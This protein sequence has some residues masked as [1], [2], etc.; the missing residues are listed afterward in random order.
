[1]CIRDIGYRE[2]RDALFAELAASHLRQSELS[3]EAIA[4]LLGYH[5]SA[6]FRRAFRRWYGLSPSEFRAA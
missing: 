1:M 4:A 2:I 6:N 3:V 5:D